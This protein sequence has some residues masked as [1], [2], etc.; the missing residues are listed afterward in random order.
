M[1]QR[2]GDAPSPAVA[3]DNESGDTGECA[4]LGQARNAVQGDHAEAVV[5]EED[6]VVGT[7]RTEPTVHL[8]VRCGIAELREQAGDDWGILS[9]CGPDHRG[10]YR[11]PRPAA[12]TGRATDLSIRRGRVRART[13]AVYEMLQADR[14]DPLGCAEDVQAHLRYA[15]AELRAGS[16]RAR[17]QATQTAQGHSRGGSGTRRA[18]G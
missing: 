15:I 3:M 12:A 2:S 17:R 14:S 5:G 13:W 10:Q 1:K 7:E 6:E 4:A 18:L 9:S 16:T 8:P 11:P